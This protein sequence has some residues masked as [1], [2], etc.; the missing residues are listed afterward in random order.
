MQEYSTKEQ[1]TSKADFISPEAPPILIEEIYPGEMKVVDW[2]LCQDCEMEVDAY[3][4]SPDGS[5]RGYCWAHFETPYGGILP[6]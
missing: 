6:F 5:R 3:I 4:Y 2:E 1:S